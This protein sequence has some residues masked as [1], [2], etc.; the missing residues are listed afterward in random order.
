MEGT[1]NN[2]RSRDNFI[3]GH[4]ERREWLD[5]QPGWSWSIYDDSYETFVVELK[6]Y[7]AQNNGS[8]A[9][10]QDYVNLETGYPLGSRVNRVRYGDDYIKGHPERREWLNSLPGWS[11]SILDDTYETFVVELKAYA[12]ENNG[13]MAP[14][15]KYV[16]RKTGYALG[17]TINNVRSRDNF[18]KGHPKRIRWLL[19]QP[20]WKWLTRKSPSG[21][22]NASR[23]AKWTEEAEWLEYLERLDA[24][25]ESLDVRAMT[26]RILEQDLFSVSDNEERRAALVERGLIQ[27]LIEVPR[28][29]KRLKVSTN[30]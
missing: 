6:A 13:S 12:A 11:W 20:G 16:N 2:V 1:I 7:A 18:I 8:M 9:P 15:F 4:P 14:P 21:E 17:T 29:A 27:V 24:D 30:V 3:K 23:R 10:R 22:T 26:Q 28:P 25:A 19:A 5:S